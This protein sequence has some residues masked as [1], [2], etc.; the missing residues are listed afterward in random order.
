MGI[1]LAVTAVLKLHLLLNDPFADIKTG[2]SLPIL[3]LAVF[4]ETAVVYIAFSAQSVGLKWGALTGLFSVMTVVAF[5]NV[6]TGKSSCGCSGAFDIHPSWFLAT[7]L[8]SVAVLIVFRPAPVAAML[9]EAVSVLGSG[10]SVAKIAALAIVGTLFIAFQTSIARDFVK[11]FLWGHDV[12][13][14]SIE[15][16]ELKA[17]NPVECSLILKNRS[18][19]ARK[20]VGIN[21][22]CSCVVPK[23]LVHASI[24]S[25]GELAVNV[26]VTPK[27]GN[28]FHQRILFFLDS[29]QQ[30]VVAADLFGTVKE[31]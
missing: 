14:T 8:I 29:S 15:L 11:S 18:N 10:H 6:V 27:S 24:P 9:T 16:G 1:L 3:W 7:D 19:S 26:K 21:S 2:N 17:A 13:A 28:D 31:N 20:I 30:Y 25:H 12:S 23:D 5:F 4:V 22:S